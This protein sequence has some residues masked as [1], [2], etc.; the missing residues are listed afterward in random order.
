M[1]GGNY[2]FLPRQQTTLESLL[3]KVKFLGGL[4]NPKCSKILPFIPIPLSLQWH[5]VSV[6]FKQ[7]QLWAGTDCRSP[8]SLTWSN[9]FHLGSTIQL[10]FIFL[11]T[12]RLFST[13]LQIMFNTIESQFLEISLLKYSCH[14]I[15]HIWSRKLLLGAHGQARTHLGNHH[16][17]FLRGSR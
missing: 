7:I 10:I 5:P 17:A 6:T 4:E 8:S 12:S 14:C 11:L 2:N 13:F 16:R 15:E 1:W 9:S 3:I